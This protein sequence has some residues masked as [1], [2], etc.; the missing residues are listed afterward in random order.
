VPTHRQRHLR[1]TQL[2]SCHENSK[3]SFHG[4][5]RAEHETRPHL[6][7]KHTHNTNTVHDDKAHQAA[8]TAGRDGGGGDLHGMPRL[9]STLHQREMR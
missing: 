6:G 8:L 9:A 7:A 5:H 4:P 3:G 2:H 1:N